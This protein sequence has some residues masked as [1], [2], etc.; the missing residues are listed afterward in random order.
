M[1]KLK[2]LD[3]KIVIVSAND[4]RFI[5]KYLKKHRIEKYV[6]HIYAARLGIKNGILTGKIFGDVI[7]TEKVG[8][9]SKIEKLYKAK[10]KDIIYIGDGLTDLPIIKRVGIG[11]L[12]CPN[13]L[14][15][16][17][18]FTNK[19]LK[20]KIERNDLFL[21]EERNLNEIMKFI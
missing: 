16:A 4:E 14:T 1:K 17:E 3:Y 9:V 8:V 12:F 5:K 18:V 10:K 20:D 7:K 21:V 6:D 19:I 13:E 11:I 15:K 2:M